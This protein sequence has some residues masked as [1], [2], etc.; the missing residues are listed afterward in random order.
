MLSNHSKGLF[1]KAISQSGCALNEWAN[2]TKRNWTVRL[3]TKLGWDGTGGDEGLHT[4]YKNLDANDIV[5]NQD[6]IKTAAE[7][8]I[9][10]F[11]PSQE[12]YDSD[13]C[14]FTAHPLELIRNPWST[15]VPLIMGGNSEEGL[16]IYRLAKEK[17]AFFETV[18]GF[19]HMHPVSFELVIGSKESKEVATLINNF[20][21]NKDDTNEQ[22]LSK[23]ID[24]NTDSIFFH[25]IV[26]SIR[27]RLEQ[28]QTTAPTY[29][30]R[31]AVDSEILN[32]KKLSF[33]G[34]YVKGNFVINYYGGRT[35]LVN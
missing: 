16:M 5:G 30:Y 24:M 13:E 34:Q 25:G 7:I 17:F 15:N 21:I 22:K 10:S 32:L 8:R 6:K 9:G 26:K 19:E 27:L 20:Y 35:P 2:Y 28:P 31:F 23:I 3:A 14:F 33:I 4:F 29:L 11:G 1:D 12:P 18:S